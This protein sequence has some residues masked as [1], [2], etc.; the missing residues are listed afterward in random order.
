MSRCGTPSTYRRYPTGIHPGTARRTQTIPAGSQPLAAPISMR[1]RCRRPAPSARSS[2]TGSRP[3]HRAT[4]LSLTRGVRYTLHVNFRTS[5]ADWI[6]RRAWPE[7]ATEP[8]WLDFVRRA[9]SRQ[10]ELFG[11][12]PARHPYWT[13]RPWPAWHFI[14]PDWTYR[15][16]TDSHSDTGHGVTDPLGLGGI[17]ERS[18]KVSLKVGTKALP[19]AGSATGR[20]CWATTSTSRCAIWPSRSPYDAP[21]LSVRRPGRARAKSTASRRQ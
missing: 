6:G 16:G 11:F 18:P 1:R 5:D 17:P 3:F 21:T 10:L 19:T 4:A 2:P 7:A 12:P 14:I 13:S 9:S 20:S 15:S 8:S